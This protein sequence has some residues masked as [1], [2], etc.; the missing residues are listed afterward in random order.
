[1]ICLQ[2]SVIVL[3]GNYDNTCTSPPS[4]KS[5]FVHKF[6]PLCYKTNGS[7]SAYMELW[8]HFGSLS[9][10]RPRIN[11]SLCSNRALRNSFLASIFRYTQAMHELFNL[12]VG[13]CVMGGVVVVGL[14]TGLEP[15]RCRCFIFRVVS[16]IIHAVLNNSQR[17]L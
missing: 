15:H 8:I 10:S 12:P 16:P 4:Y 5:F 13:D 1:M 2:D 6:C 9:S 11:H 17:F 7:C 3:N 14:T